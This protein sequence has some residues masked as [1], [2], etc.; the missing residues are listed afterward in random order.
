MSRRRYDHARG[1][2]AGFSLVAAIFIIAVLAVL[3]AFMVTIGSVQRTTV[4]QAVQAARAYQAA[5]AGVEWAIARALAPATRA[6]TCG[7]A[8]STPATNSFALNVSGLDGFNVSVTC[9]YTRHQEASDC[10]NVY[11]ITSIAQAGTFGDPFFARRQVEAKAT[12]VPGT[13]CP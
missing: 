1:R 11:R 8:P 7:A 2:Q 9:S 3:A 6:A 5:S 4:A 12:D 13:G 10:F